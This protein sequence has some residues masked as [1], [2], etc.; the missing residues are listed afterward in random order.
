MSSAR[1]V[2]MADD[3]DAVRRGV[4]LVLERAGFRVVAECVDGRTA[5]EEAIRVHPDICLLDIKMPGGGIEAAARIHAALPG[6]QIVMLT[7]SADSDDL[8][9]AL[10]AGA[11]GYLLKDIDPARLPHALNGV[12]EGEAALPR[13]LVLRLIDEFRGREEDLQAALAPRPTEFSLTTREWDVLTSLA[14]G[15]STNETARQLAITPVT[16]R[17]HVANVIRKLHVAD[18]DA[19]VDLVRSGQPGGRVELP[20]A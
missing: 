12:L 8:F 19:A 2:L 13:R 11:V 5:V 7:V 18:R 15:F 1:R 10:R 20:G 17:S 3:H 9:R 16:V 4:R 6:V 14:S